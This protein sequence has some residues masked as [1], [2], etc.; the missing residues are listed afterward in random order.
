MI[1]KGPRKPPKK[2]KRAVFDPEVHRIGVAGVGA[3]KIGE[4]FDI[5][6]P[7]RVEELL[8]KK[9]LVFELIDEGDPGK[10]SGTKKGD[11]G[12]G[13]KKGKKGE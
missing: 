7:V 3:V 2:S 8:A 9:D 11:P 5:D 4:T 10:G 13:D 12:P 1:Y 6:D